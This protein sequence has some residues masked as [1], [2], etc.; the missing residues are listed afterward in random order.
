MSGCCGSKGNILLFACS[1]CS[2]VGQ[3]ANDAAKALEQLGQGRMYCAISVAAKLPAFVKTAAQADK[4]VLIDGCENQ[5]VRQAFDSAGVPCD[6]HV[7]VANLGIQKGHF[8]NYTQADI[9]TVAG[10]VSRQLG[11]TASRGA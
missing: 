5:C 11:V 9:A 8:T 4:R 2:N 1:G 3:I 6:V 7:I 10:I